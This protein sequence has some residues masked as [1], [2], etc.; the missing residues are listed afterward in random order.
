M[1][2]N[3]IVAT[4]EKLENNQSKCRHRRDIEKSR[5]SKNYLGTDIFFLKM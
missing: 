4:M 3:C 5:F 1:H 2:Q